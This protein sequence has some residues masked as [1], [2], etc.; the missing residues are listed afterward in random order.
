M[1]FIKCVEARCLRALWNSRKAGSRELETSAVKFSFALCS[2]SA[3]PEGRLREGEDGHQVFSPVGYVIGQ[4]VGMGRHRSGAS[5][6]KAA[7][8]GPGQ[9]GPPPDKV[10]QPC[11]GRGGRRR[12][13]Q[14]GARHSS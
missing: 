2:G 13:G 1:E 12:P 9:E 6:I 11:R 7:A 3:S 14:P 8:E 5:G 4:Q 10:R